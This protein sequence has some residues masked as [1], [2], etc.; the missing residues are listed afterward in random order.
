MQFLNIP[1]FLAPTPRNSCFRSG[2]KTP[3]LGYCFLSSSLSHRNRKEYNYP[4]DQPSYF[5]GAKKKKEKQT[6]KP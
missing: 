3:S 6:I 5:W 4:E 2:S 1:Y